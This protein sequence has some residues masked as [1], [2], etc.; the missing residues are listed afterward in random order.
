MSI[1]AIQVRSLTHVVPPS[2][3]TPFGT[4]Y[5]FF[6]IVILISSAKWFT[7][8]DR[9]RVTC[10]SWDIKLRNEQSDICSSKRFLALE[11]VTFWVFVFVVWK[12]QFHISAI[13]AKPALPETGWRQT[14]DEKWCSQQSHFWTSSIGKAQNWIWLCEMPNWPTVKTISPLAN[15]LES[16]IRP[17]NPLICRFPAAKKAHSAFHQPYSR[18]SF[19]SPLNKNFIPA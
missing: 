12:A 9:E 8:M 19:N 11:Q 15:P 13:Q 5:V 2:S 4:V 17:S 3:M 16:R 14:S 6:A 7:A 10:R 1:D 18:P